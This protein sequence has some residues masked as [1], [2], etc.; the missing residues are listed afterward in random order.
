MFRGDSPRGRIRRYGRFRRRRTWSNHTGNQLVEPL[1]I[2]YPESLEQVQQIVADAESRQTTVRAVGSGHSW[3]DVAL[4]HGFLIETHGLSETLEVD[5]LRTDYEQRELLVRVEA[6]IRLRELIRWLEWRDPPLALSNMGGWDAQ[7]V[8]GVMSTSTHGSGLG[9]GPL[10]DQAVSIDI[11]GSGGKV[12]RVE[13]DRGPTDRASFENEHPDWDLKT[14][15]DWFNSV[16]VGMGCLGIIY[17]VTLK[18]VPFYYLK[19]VREVSDWTDVRELLLGNLNDDHIEVYVN[20]HKR[21]SKHLCLITRRTRVDRPGKKA[22]SRRR[23]L[24]VEL[25]G[26]LQ[27]IAP[28]LIDLIVSRWPRLSPWFL[29]TAIKAL[30]DAEYTDKWYRVLNLGTANLMPAYSMEIGV[31]ITNGGN[32]VRAM[33]RVFEV[34]A[35]HQELGEVYSTSP[36]SLRFVKRSPAYM[37]MMYA[38]EESPHD[39]MMIELIQLTRTEGGFELLAAYEEALYEFRGRPHWGQFNTLTGSHGLMQSMYRMHPTWME[40]HARLNASGVFDGPFSKRVGISRSLFK[41]ADPN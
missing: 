29:D 23:N 10:C 7:T 24:G 30:K 31:P 4:T 39:T 17:A 18:A 21:E 15:D 20:P 5:C 41:G 40:V 25:L 13:P 34:A 19:E 8:A 11:V 38:D 22:S 35:R 2:R 16:K 9:H 33:E 12:Y 27:P 26:A 6:G 14:D 28:N 37:S 32:H 36:I 3:S 1:E